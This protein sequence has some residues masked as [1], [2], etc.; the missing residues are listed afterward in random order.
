MIAGELRQKELKQPVTSHLQSRAEINAHDGECL[1]SFLYS[2]I[3]QGPNPENVATHFQNGTPHQFREGRQPPTDQS[4]P[5][6]PP[7]SSWESLG[8]IK[9]TKQIFTIID[10][11]IQSETKWHGV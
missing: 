1:A 2:C 10:S 9:V 6:T 7:S 5:D 4:D 11:Y 3:V 8:C